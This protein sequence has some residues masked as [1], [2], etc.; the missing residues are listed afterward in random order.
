MS[1]AG[2][3]RKA[4]VVVTDVS[5]S[6]AL[7]T[8]PDAV[9]M[10]GA[11]FGLHA[12]Q[13]IEQVGNKFPDPLHRLTLF[14]WR[15]KGQKY[16]AKVV[17]HLM[18]LIASGQVILGADVV[19]E[20]TIRAIGAPFFETY[21]GAFPDPSGL[22]RDGR[23][24]VTLGG[25]EVDGKVQTPFEV[26]IDD[27]VTI[28]WL[29]ASMCSAHRALC[30]LN[31]EDVVLNVIPDNLPREDFGDGRPRA[32]VLKALMGRASGGLVR[33]IGVP[34]KPDDTQRD[35][36][37]DNIAGLRREIHEGKWSGL[38]PGTIFKFFHEDIRLDNAGGQGV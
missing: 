31:D 15:G 34:E 8:D 11:L 33:V 20:R 16:K 2:D 19:N 10:L 4:Y 6:E 7:G 13:S 21:F 25:Y 24:M 32:T 18:R 22:H 36:L 12:P 28:G 37:V 29:A 1:G 26:L 17:E 3:P 23:P 38:D 5:P 35:L 9:K 27:L 14:K 30:A